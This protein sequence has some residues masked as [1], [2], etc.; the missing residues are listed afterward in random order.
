MS[1][2][3]LLQIINAL[4][5]LRELQQQPEKYDLEIESL[6]IFIREAVR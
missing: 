6:K 2:Q 4:L 5:Q 3:L 1:E